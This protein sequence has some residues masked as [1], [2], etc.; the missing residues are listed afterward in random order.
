[1]PELP[2]VETV[3]LQLLSK[4]LGKKIEKVKV[5]NEKTTGKDKNFEKKLLGQSFLYIERVGKLLAF[6]FE[7]TENQ[8]LLVHLKMTGQFFYLDKEGLI[9]GG[10]LVTEKDI[11]NLPN[12][13]TR[14]AISFSDGG[15]LFFNDMRLFGF[16]KVVDKKTK[17]LAWGK[18]G[19]EPTGEDFDFKALFERVKN[20]KTSIKA[21]LL[22]QS[23]VAGLGN[24]YVDEALWQAKIRPDR[25]TNELSLGELKKVIK[26]GGEIMKKSL[27]VGGTTFKDFVNVQG[28][29]G[30]YTKY[31]KVFDRQGEKCP[32]CG[33]VIEKTRVAGRGTHFCPHCQK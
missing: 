17:D 19:P 14:V 20:K 13:H 2:E 15:V 1:M 3:R 21:T 4:I 22:D 27:E 5:F 9:G 32:R 6:S 10:H 16:M 7:K 8:F 28:K 26:A 31:L 24:I 23:I 25:K 18:F 12:K 11:K 30:N 29:T 33:K